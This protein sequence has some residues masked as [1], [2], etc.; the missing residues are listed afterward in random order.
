MGGVYT[1]KGDKGETG[2]YGGSRISKNNLRVECYGTIDEVVSNIGSAY[3]MIKD[4]ELRQ[5]LRYI[6][7]R[8]F[9]VGAELA[10]DE[11]GIKK[12]SGRICEDD[13]VYLENTIDKYQLMLSPQ[14]G[15]IIPGGSPA[16][17]VLHVARTVT[18][19]A[20]RS[21][22]S[23]KKEQGGND[24]I[25]KFINRLSDTLFILARVEEEGS[26]IQEVKNK[27]LEKI[28]EHKSN[29]ELDL[30]LSKKKA[31]LAEKRALEMKLPIVFSVVDKSGNLMLLHRMNDSLIASI[32]ISMNKAFTA[33][34]LKMSTDKLAPLALPGGPLYGIQNTNNNRIIVFGGG[35][36]LEHNGEVIGGIGVSGGTVEQDME[37]ALYSLRAFEF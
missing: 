21:L 27:V 16:S 4:G 9:S 13:V 22:V 11:N 32:D 36:P 7:K 29:V 1:K 3:S 31:A 6:Q 18:R 23:L 24:S 34:S 26:F 12:L 10:S 28:I 15:F 17:A 2:L 33:V 5:V 30:E 37:I 25:I 8:L 19:R 35:Y 20:E 14:K